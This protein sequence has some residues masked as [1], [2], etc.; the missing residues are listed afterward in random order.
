MVATGRLE[1]PRARTWSLV[2]PMTMAFAVVYRPVLVPPF[3][4][5]A[6]RPGG[7]IGRTSPDGEERAIVAGSRQQRMERSVQ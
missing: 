6:G 1:A 7:W 2:M 5:E 3:A 4:G